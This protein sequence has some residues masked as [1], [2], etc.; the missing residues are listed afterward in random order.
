MDLTNLRTLLVAVFGLAVI[1]A[2]IRVVG[3]AHRQDT[4]EVM[5]TSFGVVV[6]MVIAAVGLGALAI[7]TFGQKVLALLGL[8]G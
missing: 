1:V 7:A 5:R 4:A 3:R 6:G 8:G 2:G